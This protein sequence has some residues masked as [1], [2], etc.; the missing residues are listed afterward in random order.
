MLY[1]ST[2]LLI[3]TF[4][5]D[6]SN[7][8]ELGAES[9]G[10]STLFARLWPRGGRITMPKAEI[11]GRSHWL[12]T[13]HIANRMDIFTTYLRGDRKALV[14]FSFEEEAGAFLNLQLAAAKDGWRVRQTSVG[15]LVSI[16]YG[17][18]WD[19]KQVVLNPVPDIGGEALADLLSM[20]R[21]DFLR[22]LL[23]EEAPSN[24]HLVPS[25]THRPQ[26]GGSIMGTSH[27]L[28]SHGDDNVAQPVPNSPPTTSTFVGA[29]E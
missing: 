25:Q 22:L 4:Q 23:G 20:H 6:E 1:V 10:R 29:S 19:T 24:L 7:L 13:K 21:N 8:S 11:A 26:E 12:I 28:I 17:P 16:L 9:P 27:N 14:V 5:V 18:C 15:E 2:G 3:S